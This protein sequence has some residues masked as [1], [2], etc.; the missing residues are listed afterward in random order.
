MSDVDSARLMGFDKDEIETIK[1]FI[2]VGKT[3]CTVQYE[4]RGGVITEVLCVD[5]GCKALGEIC[6]L[7]HMPKSKPGPNEVQDLGEN[8]K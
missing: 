2:E 7:V 6:H 8:D 3:S 5:S 4:R 1:F